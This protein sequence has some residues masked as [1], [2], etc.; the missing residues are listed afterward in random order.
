MAFRVE[1]RHIASTPLFIC[2]K[3]RGEVFLSKK[4]V[5]YKFMI[6]GAMLTFYILFAIVLF[7]KAWE[8]GSMDEF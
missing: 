3:R 4:I 6:L 8:G 1:R 2:K 5:H 7:I